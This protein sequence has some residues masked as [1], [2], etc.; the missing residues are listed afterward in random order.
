MVPQQWWQRLEHANRATTVYSS[1][2]CS[3]QCTYVDTPIRLWKCNW[4]L[5]LTFYCLATK[6][7]KKKTEEGERIVVCWYDLRGTNAQHDTLSKRTCRLHTLIHTGSWKHSFCSH[8][9]ATRTFVFNNKTIVT[10]LQ[11][12]NYECFC[13]HWWDCIF[14][15]NC[16]HQNTFITPWVCLI[17]HRGFC[18]CLTPTERLS[19]FSPL[20]FYVSLWP[21][22]KK[23]TNKSYKLWTSCAYNYK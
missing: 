13:E 16:Q 9:N 14:Y 15:L 6:R 7:N 5:Y 18:C 2:E 19:P 20:N 17:A 10:D 22:G 8:L 3:F 11:R 21:W 23:N 4:L 12:W 1:A